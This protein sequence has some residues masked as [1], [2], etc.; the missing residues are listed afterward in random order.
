MSASVWYENLT[1]VRESGICNEEHDV[2]D[3]T[4]V[5]G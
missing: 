2:D 1:D 4:K 5:E 3:R